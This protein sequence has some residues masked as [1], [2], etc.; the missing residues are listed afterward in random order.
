MN[1]HGMALPT[2]GQRSSVMTSKESARKECR[3]SWSC[4][5]SRCSPLL[6]SMHRGMIFPTLFVHY[7]KEMGIGLELK[8]SMVKDAFNSGASEL[9]VCKLESSHTLFWSMTVAVIEGTWKPYMA[10]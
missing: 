10:A 1:E 9:N 7:T 2:N 4:I 3:R 5:I 6:F 8:K